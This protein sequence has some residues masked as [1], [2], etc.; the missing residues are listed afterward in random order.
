M[1]GRA[2]FS[3]TTVAKTVVSP[4][5]ASTVA[6]ACRA[7]LPVS[8][9]SLRPA[10]SISMRCV[11]NICFLVSHCA[12]RR[13][14][15]PCRWKSTHRF[16]QLV[17]GLSPSANLPCPLAADSQS[18]DDLLVARRIAGLDVVKQPAPQ[19][20][21]LEQTTSRMI[22]VLVLLEMLGKPVDA[23]REQRDLDLG[24]TGVIFLGCE[25]LDELQLAL[26][27]QR[28]RHTFH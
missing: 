22:V 18:L 14:S 20:H 13:A 27:A 12:K 16:P 17:R 25:I 6:S 19:T 8:S 4:Y 15:A 5:C 11:S 26:C 23:L 7:I 28:H 1:P 21:H 2:V 24:R 9:T 10:H 3:A